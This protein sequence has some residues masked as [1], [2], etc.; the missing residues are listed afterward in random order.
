MST[1]AKRN[2]TIR[3]TSEFEEVLWA[4]VKNEQERLDGEGLG[5]RT[6]ATGILIGLVSREAKARGISGRKGGRGG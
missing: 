6:T 3:I 1:A 5:G 2:L 4:L